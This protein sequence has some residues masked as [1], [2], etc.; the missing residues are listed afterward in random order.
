MASSGEDGST[1]KDKIISYK[2]NIRLMKL[3]KN[4]NIYRI[5]KIKD[6]KYIG[7]NYLLYRHQAKD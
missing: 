1:Y 3:H 4:E 7:K 6:I 2:K 5:K